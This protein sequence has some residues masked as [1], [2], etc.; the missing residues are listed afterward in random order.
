MTGY[1]YILTNRKQ[2]TLYTGITNN[3]IKRTQEHRDKKHKSFTKQYNVKKLVWYEPFECFR[4]AISYE[5]R[6]KRWRRDWKINLIE[7]MNPTWD[8]LYYKLTP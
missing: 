1:V 4:E 2:G 5:K 8:D 7:K 3:I 6:I